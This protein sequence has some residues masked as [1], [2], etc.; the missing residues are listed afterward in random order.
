[1]KTPRPHPHVLD[2]AASRSRIIRK[3][4]RSRRKRR[5][6]R[7]PINVLASVL[8]TLSLYCGVASIFA[9]I[10]TQYEKAV[11]WILVAVVF[12]M[13]DGF[14]ARLT[15]SVSEFGKELDSLSDLVSFG[16][17]P[18]VLV[19]TSFLP[20]ESQL[21]VAAS[22]IN[23]IPAIFFVICGALR[24]ARYNVYQSGQRDV[25]T[26][27]PIPAAG[28]TVA[29]FVLFA[30]YLTLP[31]AVWWLNGLTLG[32]SYLMVSTVRYPKDKLKLFVL[33][34]RHAF[35]MLAICAILIAIFH[36]ATSPVVVLFPLAMGYV[37]FGLGNELHGYV[38]RRGEGVGAGEGK[39]ADQ[40]EPS[41]RAL[42]ESPPASKSG[43]PL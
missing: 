18:A 42:P 35:R 14:V 31:G 40:P 33:A 11:T 39:E 21:T 15:K 28:V 2:M 8:T 29:T 16:V 23:V 3:L 1:M 6:R 5:L 37:A 43:D 30:R 7:R 13:L 19:Y 27:L 24:L 41:S 20:S 4:K 36:Y 38:K 26:G 12:D 32:L 22:R 10:G 25:F 17:A 34:P 9:S